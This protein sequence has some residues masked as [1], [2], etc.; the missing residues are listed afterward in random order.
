MAT[1]PTGVNNQH[2]AEPSVSRCWAELRD[3]ILTHS[4]RR[5]TPAGKQISFHPAEDT[6]DVA[7][8]ERSYGKRS[9]N[10]IG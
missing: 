1:V 7:S 5:P 8:E 3:S 2:D 10:D 4:T 6:G 9:V